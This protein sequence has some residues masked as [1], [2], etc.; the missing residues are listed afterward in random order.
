[1][2]S[3]EDFIISPE[4]LDQINDLVAR[5]AAK[6]EALGETMDGISISFGFGPYGRTISMSYSGG[7]EVNIC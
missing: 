2:F 6:F 1:M 4:N 5:N 7:P 3:Y